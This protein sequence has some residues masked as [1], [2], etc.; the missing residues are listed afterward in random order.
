MEVSVTQ[1]LVPIVV[2][3]LVTFLRQ[4]TAQLDGPRAYW[5]SVVLNIIA[6][7]VAQLAVDG[8]PMAGAALGLG[9]GAIV[10]PG[11]ATSVK[12]IGLSKLIKPRRD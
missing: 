7:V 9:T 4:V 2:S 11:L 6:Q 12:R 10:G 8:D 5:A 3:A 1:L